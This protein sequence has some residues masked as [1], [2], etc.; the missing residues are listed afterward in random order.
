ALKEAYLTE[1]FP[2][3]GETV[4]KRRFKGFEGEWEYKSLESLLSDIIDNRGKTPPLNP[5]GKYSLIEVAS[6]GGRN[7]DYANVTKY[8][9]KRTYDSFLR[10]YISENDVLYSTV[11]R[12]GLVSLM[13]N[14]HFAN[15]AQNIVGFRFK[16]NVCS[17]YM[18]AL[19]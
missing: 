1:M 4:P 3:E 8:I 13:D 19:L 7:T 6:L 16:V 15:I 2:Q 12:I 14:N 17:N 18:F 9:D 10:G 11:G 5:E